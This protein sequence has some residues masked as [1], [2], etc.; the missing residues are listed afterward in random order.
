M[1]FDGGHDVSA[2]TAHQVN[3]YPV[4]FLALH[5]VLVI[6]PAMKARGRE[7]G[8]IGGKINL[9]R[10]ERTAAFGDQCP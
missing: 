8:T 6:V 7:A 10:I 5:A 2:D 1:D 9:N 3:L 4:V